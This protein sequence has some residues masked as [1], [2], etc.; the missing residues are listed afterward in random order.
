MF[1]PAVLS[2]HCLVKNVGKGLFDCTGP[3]MSRQWSLLGIHLALSLCRGQPSL[4]ASLVAACHNYHCM[5][6]QLGS[7]NP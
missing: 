1:V 2:R 4:L 3:Q 6:T 5:Q 7:R